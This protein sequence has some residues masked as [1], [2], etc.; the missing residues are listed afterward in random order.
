ML[1]AKGWKQ[2][3]DKR[4][5]HMEL[6]PRLQI[7]F[8]NQVTSD[9]KTDLRNTYEL[10][11]K[12]NNDS[13]EQY[14]FWGWSLFLKQQSCTSFCHHNLRVLKGTT[15]GY[16]ISDITNYRWRLNESF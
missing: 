4:K 5:T 11:P 2:G 14:I 1:S 13:P 9:N 8:K 12:A 6:L 16:W 3:V 10:P 7:S 15:T